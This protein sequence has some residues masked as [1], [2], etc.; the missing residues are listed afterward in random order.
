MGILPHPKIKEHFVGKLIGNFFIK[1][2][3]R[4][5]LFP[6]ARPFLIGPLHSFPRK[7]VV[8]VPGHRRFRRQARKF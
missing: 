6:V 7:V 5:L 3:Y 2:N 1:L 4:F 8:A